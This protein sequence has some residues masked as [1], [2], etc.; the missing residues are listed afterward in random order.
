M[1]ESNQ[2]VIIGFSSSG[3]HH[4]IDIHPFPKYRP[5]GELADSSDALESYKE[6]NGH[7]PVGRALTLDAYPLQFVRN[8]IGGN[9]K[10]L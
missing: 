8:L 6:R 1:S 9:G 4:I 5:D 10:C 2:Y 3:Q 7:R